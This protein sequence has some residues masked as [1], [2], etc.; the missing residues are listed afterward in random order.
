MIYIYSDAPIPS[1][2]SFHTAD[3]IESI[4][5]EESSTEKENEEGIE[6]NPPSVSKLV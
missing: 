5:D 4:E 2:N 3:S 6:I 1:P